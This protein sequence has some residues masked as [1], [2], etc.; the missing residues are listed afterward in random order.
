VT[1]A[2]ARLREGVVG[3]VDRIRRHTDLPVLVGFGI[4]TPEHVR[5]VAQFSDG[6]V[7]GSA[8]IDAIALAPIAQ[9]PEKAREFVAEMR[10]SGR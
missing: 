3:L 1:G 2:R 8:L 10:A 7:F 4:S 5:E 9:A 6:A